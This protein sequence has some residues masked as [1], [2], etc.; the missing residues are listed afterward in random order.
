MKVYKATVIVVD[1]GDELNDSEVKLV[2]ENTRYPNRCMSPHV[3]AV[4]SV[5][6]GPWDDDLPINGR[7]TFDSEVER[8]FPGT[9]VVV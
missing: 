1:A 6:L 4:E 3:I 8:L 9:K 5:E 2:I 7:D